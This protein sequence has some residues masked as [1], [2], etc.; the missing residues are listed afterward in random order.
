MRSLSYSGKDPN[1]K[2]LNLQ[3]IS[4]TIGSTGD[5]HKSVSESQENGDRFHTVLIVV[6]HT[7]TPR[8][9]ILSVVSTR[10]QT[11]F[12]HSQCTQATRLCHREGLF[13]I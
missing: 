3:A 13:G 12:N 1:F 2:R 7:L 5:T 10:L 9:H 8:P 11:S 6:L 4:V